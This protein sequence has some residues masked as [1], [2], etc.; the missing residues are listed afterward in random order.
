MTVVICGSLAHPD[1]LAQSA[2]AA[3]PPRGGEG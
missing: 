2:A 1:L 3:T